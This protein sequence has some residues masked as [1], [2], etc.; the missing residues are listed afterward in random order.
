MGFFGGSYIFI[1][2]GAPTEKLKDPLSFAAE[3]AEFKTLRFRVID[4]VFTTPAAFN[5]T[6]PLDADF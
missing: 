5:A 3:S 4:P 6:K 1:D 2:T